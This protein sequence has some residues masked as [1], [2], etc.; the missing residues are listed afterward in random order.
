MFVLVSICASQMLLAQD[1]YRLLEVEYEY[2]PNNN[3]EKDYDGSVDVGEFEVNLSLP[4]PR[5]NGDAFVFGLGYN[6][7]TLNTDFAP[8]IQVLQDT[9]YKGVNTF[10]RY[11]FT[12]AYS[13]K[14]NEQKSIVAMG[15]A[16]LASDMI[17]PGPQDMLY[18]GLVLYN[19]KKNENFT[20]KYGMY[21]NEEHYGYLLIPILGLDWKLGEKWQI[22]GNLPRSLTAAY[23]ASEKLRC[24][25]IF[26]A[27][28][29]TYRLSETSVHDNINDQALD[30]YVYSIKNTI[31]GFGELYLGKSLVLRG[32]VG[33][34]LFRR[35]ELYEYQEGD[36]FITWGI[37]Y[38]TERTKI[39]DV[40]AFRPFEDGV[41]LNASLEYRFSFE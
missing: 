41:V 10:T 3:Y 27:P 26:E 30:T 39:S 16:R 18:G 25:F 23:T 5:E 8:S 38:G 22:F 24:G 4:I 33:Y 37:E 11:R 32:R 17:S 6:T 13:K 31:Y 12:G 28:N 36:S 15:F 29:R 20:I 1:Y 2:G 35:I 7:L 14:L 34:A 21:F 9:A 40:P 19:I